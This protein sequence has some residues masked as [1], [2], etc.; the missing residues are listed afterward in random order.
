MHIAGRPKLHSQFFDATYRSAH[1][2]G[3]G[4]WLPAYA[5]AWHEGRRDQ[6]VIV[7]AGDME[8]HEATAKALALLRH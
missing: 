3:S 6:S 8:P 5:E 2:V 4:E 7:Y 1:H